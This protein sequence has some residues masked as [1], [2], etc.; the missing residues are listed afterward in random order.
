MNF[1]GCK[2][3]AVLALKKERKGA[4]IVQKV[5]NHDKNKRKIV[6]KGNFKGYFQYLCRKFHI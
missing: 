6:Q 5:E 4:A 2:G 3:T 1:F